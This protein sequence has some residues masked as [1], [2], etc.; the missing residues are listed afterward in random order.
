MTHSQVPDDVLQVERQPLWINLLTL[1]ALSYI[2]GA[3]SSSVTLGRSFIAQRHLFKILG[4]LNL[5]HIFGICFNHSDSHKFPV[6]C[7]SESEESVATFVSAR[8]SA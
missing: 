6:L 7:A 4:S 8:H 3:C 1:T 2:C 5:M